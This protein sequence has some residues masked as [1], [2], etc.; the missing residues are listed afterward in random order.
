MILC[1]TSQFSTYKRS[2]KKKEDLQ[3]RVRRTVQ[4]T[5]SIRLLVAKHSPSC[6]FLCK[7]LS[8]D[9]AFSI[10]NQ[11]FCFRSFTHCLLSQA[12]CTI[13]MLSENSE[14]SRNSTEKCLRLPIELMSSRLGI[15]YL[16]IYLFRAIFSANFIALFGFLCRSF[17]R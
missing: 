4:Q 10:Y 14:D 7:S 9:P 8:S 1:E 12:V 6:I 2:T 17:D 13:W 11:A 3:V 16:F 5:V 15:S